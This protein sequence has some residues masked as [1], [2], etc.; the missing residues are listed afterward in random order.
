M[1]ETSPRKT[2]INWR[3]VELAA[4]FAVVV[5]FL[6]VGNRAGMR[7]LGVLTIAHAVV[8]LLDK[9]LPYGWEG[10]EPSGYLTGGIVKVYAVALA[11]L[12]LTLLVRPDVVLALLGPF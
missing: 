12:G 10:Q 1:K 8:T 5:L 11:A 9:R 6:F 2:S 3:V 7:G 4:V